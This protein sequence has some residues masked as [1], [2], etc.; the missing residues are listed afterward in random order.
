MYA[1]AVTGVLLAG[2]V[3]PAKAYDSGHSVGETVFGGV[4]GLLFLAAGAVA[5]HRRPDNRV[6]LLMVLVG[7]GFFA[8]DVRFVPWP[9]PY[10]L[11]LLLGMASSGFVAH[12]VL[13]FPTGRLESRAS[14]FLAAGA[15][16]VVFGFG[17]LGVLFVDPAAHG[18][19][20]PPNLLLI[21]PSPTPLSLV[22]SLVF[23]SGSVLAA[24]VVVVLVRRWQAATRPR[25]RILAPVF[26]TGLVG[27]VASAC[28]SL[29]ELDVAR[30]V[31]LTTYRV[32]FCLLP[33]AFLAGVLR[34]ELARSGVGGLLIDLR[35]A[36]SPAELR[37]RL[38]VALGDPSLRV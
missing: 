18:Q 25:R 23:G 34:V 28:A 30:V 11:G 13:A 12:L 8:E 2:V 35:Q 37:D 4:S 20:Y 27:S 33:L 22:R 16:L 15:Y 5:H 19:S 10:T 38:A 6:G 14:R 17:P 7:L 3:L 31:L 24:G 1:L 36:L 29:G 32:A 9:L 21:D 26:G